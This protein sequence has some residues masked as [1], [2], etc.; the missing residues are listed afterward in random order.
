MLKSALFFAAALPLVAAPI[1]QA[2]RE[3]PA[4]GDIKHVNRDSM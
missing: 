4:A 3:K 1:S 2:D